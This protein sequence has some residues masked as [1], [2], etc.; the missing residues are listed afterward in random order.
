MKAPPLPKKLT[1]V[2]NKGLH[3]VALCTRNPTFKAKQGGKSI[4]NDGEAKP[5][6][7][8]KTSF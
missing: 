7:V 8:A 1:D 4:A 6:K 2:H 5:C 3:G